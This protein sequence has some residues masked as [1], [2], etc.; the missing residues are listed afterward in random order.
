MESRQFSSA[1]ILERTM[2]LFPVCLCLAGWLVTPGLLCAQMENI[3]GILHKID[4]KTGVIT[5]R[6]GKLGAKQEKTFSLLRPDLEVVTEKG[7][8]RLAELSVGNIV[9]LHL[10]DDDD[11]DAIRA[12]L[13]VVR[14]ALTAIDLPRRTIRVL[15]EDLTDKT[16][17]VTGNTRI[18]H[19]G[20]DLGLA[21][22]KVYQWLEITASLDRK[23]VLTIEAHAPGTRNGRVSSGKLEGNIILL[24]VMS[25]TLLFHNTRKT[26]KL[27]SF[28]VPKDL[29]TWVQFDKRPVDILNGPLAIA[30]K[31]ATL[32]LSPDRKEARRILADAPLLRCQ[33][34]AVDIK[35]RR[36]T[37]SENGATKTW[38]IPADVKVMNGRRKGKAED[39]RADTPVD[40]VLSLDRSRLRAVVLA[41]P[42]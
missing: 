10:N 11:V 37:V 14:A 20:K 6:P 3:S 21:D 31:P 23:D 25:G 19:L 30:S 36:L 24:D 41:N 13:P 7:R 34:H 35:N 17:T 12:E 15:A 39:L 2:R 5:I 27:L 18:V 33:I 29:S 1:S 42:H 38:D 9:H 16:F 4:V 22:L 32:Y 26:E 40:L 28:A 8:F